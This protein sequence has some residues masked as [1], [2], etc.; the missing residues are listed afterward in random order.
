MQLEELEEILLT[1]S[2]KDDNKESSSVAFNT[3]YRGYS[4]LL[5]AIV[6][7]NL[8]KMGIYNEQLYEATINNVFIKVY[9][10]PLSFE[11]PQNAKNDNCFKA[12]L[13]IVASNEI[14]TLIKEYYNKE[15]SLEVVDDEPLIESEDI[16]EELAD[17]VNKK[18]M[19]DAL[20]TL[21]ERD[22][23]IMFT[24][25]NYYEEGKKTPSNVLNDLCK[26]HDTTK[27]NIRKIKERSEKKIIDFFAQHSQ[28]KP[29][30]N[31]K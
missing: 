21:S 31:V 1:I 17:S 27:L 3:L 14:K 24:L 25:Y 30:K 28:L 16:N 23:A 15:K 4:K 8:K 2:Y 13:S 5:S 12:W 9:E 26:L 19:I 6:K 18:L 11:I 20:N 7:S 22:K 29:L 10:N